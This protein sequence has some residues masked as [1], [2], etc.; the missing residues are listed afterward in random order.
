MYLRKIGDE[1]TY[2]Y[3]IG[4]LRRDY[5]N[6]SFPRPIERVNLARFNVYPVIKNNP[7]QYDETREKA[8]EGTPVE[9]LPGIFR[10]TWTIESMTQ[11]ERQAKR[12]ALR[13]MYREWVKEYI[14]SVAIE[15]DYDDF[16]EAMLRAAYTNSDQSKVIAYAGFVDQCYS[17]AKTILQEIASGK[18]APPDKTEFFDLLDN[19]DWDAV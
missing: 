7:P 16:I 13:A 10:Q 15:Q 2:P 8:V 19:F 3:Y 14:N 1:I 9:E 11:G 18:R 5:P 6:T 4:Q 17:Q 12:K